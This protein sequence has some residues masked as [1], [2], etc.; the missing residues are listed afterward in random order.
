MLGKLAA[1]L[2]IFGLCFVL[3]VP[4]STQIT[5]VIDDT[6]K[7]SITQNMENADKF[8]AELEEDEKEG[9]G[10]FGKITSKVKNSTIAIKE[11]AETLVSNLI[12][13]IAVMIVTSCIIPLLTLWVMTWLAK[14]IL[15]I[16]IK[17]PTDRIK[18]FGRRNP[19]EK[20]AIESEIEE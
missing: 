9:K 17:V 15:G 10:V 6:H 5:K 3:L 4:V 18:S 7:M 12:D 1:K 8:V 20:L 2:V 19:E 11:K 16:Q 13:A 14:T